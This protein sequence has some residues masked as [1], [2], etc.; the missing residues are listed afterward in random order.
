MRILKQT[1][2]PCIVV[3]YDG[4]EELPALFMFPE[5]EEEGCCW[6]LLSHSINK[7][8]AVYEKRDK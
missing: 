8:I 6:Q 2:R 5:K 4:K 1:E 7:G 3:T